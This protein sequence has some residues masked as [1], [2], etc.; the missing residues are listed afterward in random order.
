VEAVLG[1]FVDTTLPAANRRGIAA[2]AMKVLGA[3]HYLFPKAGITPKTLIR[4]ALSY[5][6][7]LAIVGCSNP[8]EVKT[9]ADAGRYFQPMTEAERQQITDA[10]QPHAAQ[11]AY[12]RGPPANPTPID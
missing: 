8:R 11:L 5:P 1:G 6:I 2:I 12:Y 9:L 7:T 3:S 4:F 10:F